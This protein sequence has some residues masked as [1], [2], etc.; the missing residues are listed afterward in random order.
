MPKVPS[1]LQQKP[2]TVLDSAFIA[3]MPRAKADARSFRDELETRLGARDGARAKPTESNPSKRR[4]DESKRP[5][6]TKSER[7]DRA[8]KESAPA[9]TRDPAATEAEGPSREVPS[10]ESPAEG[11]ETVV[12]TAAGSP[13]ENSTDPEAPTDEPLPTAP[14]QAAIVDSTKPKSE[15]EIDLSLRTKEIAA[16]GPQDTNIDTNVEADAKRTIGSAA[17]PSAEGETPT[18]SITKPPAPGSLDVRTKPPQAEREIALPSDDGFPLPEPETTGEVTADDVEGATEGVLSA[19][20]DKRGGATGATPSPEANSSIDAATTP[21][22]A[23]PPVTPGFRPRAQREATAAES[24]AAISENSSSAQDAELP[25]NPSESDEALLENEDPS[26]PLTHS[27]SPNL[28]SA[29]VSRFASELG[30]VEVKNVPTGAPAL[31]AQ[32]PGIDGVTPKS[33]ADAA[34]LLNAPPAAANVPVQQILAQVQRAV[35]AGL[36][37][38]RIRLDPPSLGSL[39]LKFAM[40]G[41]SLT[42][43]VRASRPEVVE[44]LKND[45]AGFADTLSKA[46]I[47]L[48]SLDVSLDADHG[49]EASSFREKLEDAGA[50]DP[51]AA[52]ARTNSRGTKTVERSVATSALLDVMA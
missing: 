22:V 30:N 27:T 43:H 32:T 49:G 11:D 1:T 8:S 50:R 47:D 44:A 35:R 37:E 20:R 51:L 36:H 48:T 7:S 45:L 13:I 41:D 46:G 31:P 25:A 33:T 39:T 14:T 15:F 17:A 3:P 12:E 6:D 34:R 38:L 4:V 23:P 10:T 16:T 28:R 9:V 19:Q 29:G 26:T 2:T 40:E 52:N 42:V 5:D 18:P 21:T 24:P